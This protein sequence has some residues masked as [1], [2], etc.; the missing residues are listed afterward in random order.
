MLMVESA[1]DCFAPLAMTPAVISLV[2]GVSLAPAVSW[3]PGTS[4]N[5]L[6]GIGADRIPLMD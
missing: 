2:A 3:H 6:D 4:T 1:R 5:F